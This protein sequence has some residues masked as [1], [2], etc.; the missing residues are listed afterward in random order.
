MLEKPVELCLYGLQ[1]DELARLKRLQKDYLETL[2]VKKAKLETWQKNILGG[3]DSFCML[4]LLAASAIAISS[5]K[6]GVESV[7][8]MIGFYYVFQTEAGYVLEI[9]K[10]L[11]IC[12]NLVQRISVF[13]EAQERTDGET[14]GEVTSITFRN[15]TFSYD[16]KND[17]LKNCSEQ[18]AMHE[19]NV[20]CGENGTGKSTLLKLLLGLYPGY[21]GEILINGKELGSLNP[22]KWR[23]K[24]A[25]VEQVPFLFE[26]TV[27][28]NVKLGQEVSE[29]K[30]DQVPGT[31]WN[32]PSGRP[33]GWWRKIGTVRRRMSENRDCAGAFTKCR[34]VDSGRADEPPG[35]GGKT[36]VDGFCSKFRS[37]DDLC[38]A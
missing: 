28:E 26:G 17:I 30:V 38:F 37:D 6:M 29:K 3:M 14:V 5:G 33:Q 7:T 35:R 2:F 16:G 24:C 13:Y 12:K 10:Q 11:P 1:S 31:C 19:K 15:V 25:F 21:Q 18:I 34:G 36:M 23:E 4:V 32:R 9:V 22:A 20:I 27:R 8:A